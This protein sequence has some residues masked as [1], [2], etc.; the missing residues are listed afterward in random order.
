M[1]VVAGIIYSVSRVAVMH[2]CL[3]CGV[4]V[5][6]RAASGVSGYVHRIIVMLLLNTVNLSKGKKALEN[7]REVIKWTVGPCA[8]EDHW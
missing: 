5:G 7:M 3:R 8:K 4:Q 1:K 2:V 6:K